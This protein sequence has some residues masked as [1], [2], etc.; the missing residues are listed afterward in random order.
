[1]NSRSPFLMKYPLLAFLFLVLITSCTTTADRVHVDV[2]KITLAPVKIERY[3]QALFKIPLDQLQAGLIAIQPRYL[4]FLGTDLNDPQKLAEMHAYLTNPRTIEFHEMVEAKYPTLTKVEEEFTE[5]FKH[6]KYHF[7][8]LPVPHVYTYISGGDYESPIRF[9]DSVMII[10]LDNYLGTDFK[11]YK[12]DGLSLYRTQRMQPEF[13]VPQSMMTIA[14]AL[15]PINPAINTLLE[16]MVDAGKRLFLVDAFI[17]DAADYLKFGYTPEKAQWVEENESHIWAAIVEN[18][19]LYASD[20][21]TI[22]TFFADGPNTPSFGTDSPP[23]LG[24]WIGWKIVASYMNHN[25]KVT[26]KELIAET[27]AQKI[28]TKSGYKPKKR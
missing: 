19:M 11:P 12:N 1:M 18:R 8:E 21:Q 7:P 17:P 20:G 16:Q 24:E 14:S 3:D 26:F 6:L 2:S 10:G 28:L 4:F 22:R 9:V 27:D 15:S 5:A 23:R 13:I 25:P